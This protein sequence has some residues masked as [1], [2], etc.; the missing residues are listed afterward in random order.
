MHLAAQ[1]GK[2]KDRYQAF[3]KVL[4]TLNRGFAIRKE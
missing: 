2:G 3:A 1:G 4:H